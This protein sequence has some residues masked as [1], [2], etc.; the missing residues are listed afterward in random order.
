MGQN[1]LKIKVPI[2]HLNMV[3]IVEVGLKL[4]INNKRQ[5]AK[6]IKK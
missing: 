2:K 4:K 5:K 6:D 3:D 1:K